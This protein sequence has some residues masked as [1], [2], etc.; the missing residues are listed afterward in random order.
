MDPLSPA[1][2]SMPV[3]VVV[4]A[5]SALWARTSF[6]VMMP[7]SLIS[8]LLMV[9]DRLENKTSYL[10]LYCRNLYCQS[11]G[12]LSRGESHNWPEMR[13]ADVRILVLPSDPDRSV[14]DLFR[15]CE[16]WTYCSRT[17]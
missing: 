12:L 2:L 13:A 4:S 10:L 3:A 11:M 1:K 9:L 8:K 6:F 7:A 15:S 5:R 16:Q 17:S 14:T